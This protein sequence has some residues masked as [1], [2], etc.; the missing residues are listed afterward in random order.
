[1]IYIF[2]LMIRVI[3]ILNRTDR[4]K[5]GKSENLTIQNSPL[6]MNVA[7]GGGTRSCSALCSIPTHLTV[8]SCKFLESFSV[9][10][11]AA[12]AVAGVLACVQNAEKIL[13][14]CPFNQKNIAR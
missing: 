7:R 9:K 1:M 4:N 6:G 5:C 8:F 12:G 13:S 11:T 3:D 2:E 14:V 10:T